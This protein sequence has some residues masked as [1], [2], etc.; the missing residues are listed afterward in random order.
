MNKKW[1]QAAIINFLIAA[2]IGALLRF[3]FVMEV[4]GIKY[5]NFLHAH[6]HIAMLGWVYMALYA[7]LIHYFL[8]TEKQ[9][10]VIYQRL[11]WLTQLSVLGMAISFPIQGY[12]AVSI[13]FSTLHI[14][15]SYGFVR[16]FWRDM[17]PEKA[18]SSRWVKMALLFMVL[19]TIGVWAMGPIMVSGFRGSQWYYM[20]VQFYLHFQF[21][22]WFIFAI[23]AIFFRLMENRSVIFPPQ[24]M[25]RFFL[26][27]LISCLLTYA[28]AVA[29]SQPMLIVFIIN[30]V[31]VTLQLVALFYGIKLLRTQQGQLLMPF[32]RLESLLVRIAASSFALKI[33]IQAFVV[34]PF[35]AEAA[36][37]IRNY[38]VGFIHLLLL[39]AVSS[40]LLAVAFR[41]QLLSSERPSTRIG[42]F[43]LVL[44]F[45]LSECLLFLQGTMLWWG[46]GFLP[47]YY[48]L[49]F[50]CS[51]LLPLGLLLMVPG[52]F[53]RYN[54]PT[55]A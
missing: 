36:Y 51:L 54:K 31:G 14:L 41:E 46:K 30:G 38:V 20:A 39:G 12:G 21:N 6:S 18:I 10:R 45:V 16:L 8:P 19:S 13:S 32:T 29:W 24:L 3:A 37:T 27:L 1:L 43:S 7:L 2:S 34:L 5:K 28:L 11:F 9:E 25:K 52:Q 40:F 50:G 49:L 47:Q 23:L 33:I 48:E 26:F 15:C 53:K 55:S 44:G 17:G 35:V 4:P 22:G 42:V